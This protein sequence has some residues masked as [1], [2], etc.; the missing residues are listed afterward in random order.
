MKKVDVAFRGWGEHWPLGTL[1]DAGAGVVFEYSPEALRR[2]VELS[3]LH[4]PLRPQAFSG[5]ASHQSGLPGFIAD[6]L[7]DGWGLLLMD[8]VFLKYGLRPERLSPLDRLSFIGERALGALAFAPPAALEL[9]G[10]DLTLLELARAAGD[11]IDDRDTAALQALAV[12]GGSPQGAR[13][14]AL[15]QYEPRSGRMSTKPDAEGQPW[16]VKFPARAEHKEVCAIEFAYTRLARECGIEFPESRV[17]DL[18]RDLAA[19]GVARFDR[20]D[21]MR[22]PVHSAAGALNADFRLPSL[23]YRALLRATHFFTRDEQEVRKAYARCV[24][25]V[26]FHNRDDHA[27]NFAFRMDRRFEWKLAPGYDLTFS[28][29]PGGWHQTSVMGE[30]RAPARG[31]LLKLAADAGVPK[32]KATEC[33][34]RCRAVAEGLRAGLDEGGVRK[35]TRQRIA[36][37]VD[38]CVARCG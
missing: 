36:A 31:D 38:A 7:P 12:V 3:P 11:V 22:V 28:H 9:D 25:N 17:F 32:G 13:P 33:I 4:A 15:V 37:E 5:F 29:G 27:K 21:G 16:L 23:D 14:K 1:A 2:G 30:A 6:A 8:R 24:F 35:T 26:V 34:E 20:E 18:S 10:H 19:F